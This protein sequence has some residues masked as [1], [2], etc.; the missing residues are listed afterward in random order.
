M[1]R[2]DELG[3]VEAG[4]LADLVILG[5]DPLADVEHLSDIEYVIKGAR[6][7]T[8]ADLLKD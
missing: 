2:S 4:K 6:V 1:G 5:S 7:F 3:T 8:P